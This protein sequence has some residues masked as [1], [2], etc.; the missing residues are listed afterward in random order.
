MIVHSAAGRYTLQFKGKTIAQCESRDAA[1]ALRSK[2][3]REY[4]VSLALFNLG[5]YGT[6]RSPLSYNRVRSNYNA[7]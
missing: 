6:R 7:R 1:K 3:Q 5:S 2:L 4:N